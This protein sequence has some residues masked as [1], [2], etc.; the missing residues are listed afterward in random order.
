MDVKHKRIC[1]TMQSKVIRQRKIKNNLQRKYIVFSFES[2]LYFTPWRIYLKKWFQI[3]YI[4]ISQIFQFVAPIQLLDGNELKCL[5]PEYALMS[6]RV[7]P[8]TPKFKKQ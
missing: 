3:I 6:A 8:T 1:I 2:D 4:G 7:Y 5:L